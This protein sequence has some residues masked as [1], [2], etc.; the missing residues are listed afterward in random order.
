METFRISK[1]I[2]SICVC[3]SD[4]T[5]VPE[6]GDQGEYTLLGS[7]PVQ[8]VGWRSQITEQFSELTFNQIFLMNWF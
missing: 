1:I 3:Q 7:V 5:S 8:W 6:G 2:N 4:S